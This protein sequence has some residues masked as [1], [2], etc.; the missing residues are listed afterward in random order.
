MSRQPK[1]DEVT[2][3]SFLDPRS[4]LAARNF[5]EGWSEVGGDGGCYKQISKQGTKACIDAGLCFF[6]NGI[7][8]QSR[9]E[10]SWL[11]SKD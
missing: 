2:L 9:L 6:I 3:H 8:H 11:S 4:F 7:Q 10:P 5:S 1:A